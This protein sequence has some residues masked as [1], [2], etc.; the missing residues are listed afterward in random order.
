M[1]LILV[2]RRHPAV[3]AVECRPQ[4]GTVA[5]FRHVLTP[6]NRE[7]NQNDMLGVLGEQHALMS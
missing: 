2:V 6:L 7:M 3:N 4:E 1:D 5:T